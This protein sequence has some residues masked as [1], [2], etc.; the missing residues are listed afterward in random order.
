METQDLKK[1]GLKVT[2]P[3]VKILQILEKEEDH[4][5]SAEAIY[6]ELLGAG[7]EIGLATV[8]RVLTQFEAAGL[9][10]RHH[11]EGNQAVFELERGRHHD[12]IVCVKCGRVD[13]FVDPLIEERQQAIANRL[14]YTIKDHALIIYGQCSQSSCPCAKDEDEED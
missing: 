2:L 8:Y 4:H 13:E 9:V 3:R 6:R 12:H 14:G 11:F 10:S 1:A 7:E 5:M